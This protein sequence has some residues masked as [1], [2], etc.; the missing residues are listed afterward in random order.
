MGLLRSLVNDE[1]DGEQETEIPQENGLQDQ[2]DQPGRLAIING[3]LHMEEP[4][5]RG[6]WPVLVPGPRVKLYDGEQL[7]TKPIVVENIEGLSITVDQ[8]PPASAYEVIVSR[9]KMEVLLKTSFRTGRAF[10]LCDAD[11]EQRLVLKAEPAADLPAKPIDPKLVLA[12]LKKE[13]I[14][15]DLIHPE[16]IIEAC[17]GRQDTEVVI[18]RG[19]APVPPVD[20][21]IEI[22]CSLQTR[23]S[24]EAQGDR[25]DFLD[26]GS[27][28][29][30]NAGDVLACLHHPVPGTPGKDVYG[31]VVPPPAA[32]SPRLVAGS[33]VKLVKNGTM[34][35]AEVTGRP[36]LRRGVLQVNPQLVIGQNVDLST[37]NVEFRGDVAVLGDVQE[38]LTVKAGGS[39]DVRG[40]VFHA[41]IVAEEDVI[42]S[43]KLIGGSVV[44]GTDQ[45]GLTKAVRLL[46]LL[47][48]ELEQLLAAFRQLKA[49]PRL[50]V[51][52][53][54]V[55]GDGYLIKLILEARFSH[56]P[57]KFAVLDAL[58]AGEAQ[59]SE[60][61]LLTVINGVRAAAKRFLGAAPL[62]F[63]RIE[64][65]AREKIHLRAYGAELEQALDSAADIYVYYCQNAKL[66]ATGNIT[67]TGPLAY[68]CEVVAGD[69]LR[70][71]GN[72]RS[73][74]YAATTAILAKTVG[75]TGMGKT[76]L[77]V[78][79]KGVIGA[80][81]FCPGVRL[82]I[83]SVQTV[84]EQECLTTL[85]YVQDGKLHSREFRQGGAVC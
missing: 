33:G 74:F 35:V 4:K 79:D 62:E 12:H 34:A 64:E 47:D 78:G 45:P 29:A 48:R 68:D 26:R 24:S 70:V 52:D 60:E 72:C 1:V 41:D 19:V 63:K 17:L 51:A 44:A 27:F 77:C 15:N 83:G 39:V 11:F 46:K 50:S 13:G 18:A 22:V 81:K 55:R 43:D 59:S 28:N 2:H 80:D 9:D 20:G 37:G 5:G 25:V 31:K 85:F 6:A 8:E 42:I 82:R 23:F 57:K 30:V 75:A 7:V 58:L 40:S 76:E 73:G 3:Q 14:Q 56:I 84:I 38:S 16:A 61:E 36:I 65:V 67:I 69:T 21:R 71:A 53:L 54:S 49:H 10:R 32:R 66:E